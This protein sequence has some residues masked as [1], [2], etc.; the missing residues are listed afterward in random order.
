MKKI[1]FKIHSDGVQTWRLNGEYHRED[2]PA[3]T[4]SDGYQEWYLNGELQIDNK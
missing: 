2:G 4:Y 3:L 1:E